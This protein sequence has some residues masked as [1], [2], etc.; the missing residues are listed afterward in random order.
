MVGL[1]AGLG[2]RAGDW[3]VQMLML[4]AKPSSNASDDGLKPREGYDVFCHVGSSSLNFKAGGF[5]AR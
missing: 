2:R 3:S 5:I 1:A 4:M